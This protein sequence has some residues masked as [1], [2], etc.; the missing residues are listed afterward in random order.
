MWKGNTG[1]GV[2]GEGGDYDVS[3]TFLRA[4]FYA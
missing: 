1:D 3:N 2:G 4:T